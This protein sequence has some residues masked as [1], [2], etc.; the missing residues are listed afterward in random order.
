MTRSERMDR[1]GSRLDEWVHPSIQRAVITAVMLAMLTKMGLNMDAV[2]SVLGSVRGQAETNA[3]TLAQI[4]ATMVSVLERQAAERR[5]TY[6]LTN[7]IAEIRAA[8]KRLEDR[9]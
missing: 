9:P 2:N 7:D 6:T 8:L 3:V 1:A 4:E 5:K